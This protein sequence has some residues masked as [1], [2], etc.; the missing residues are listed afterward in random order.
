MRQSSF[1]EK[2]GVPQILPY[3][4]DHSGPCLVDQ[5]ARHCQIGLVGRRK[6][7]VADK[8]HEL[9]FTHAF[10]KAVGQCRASQIVK[11]TTLTDARSW[12]RPQQ[13]EILPREPSELT[14]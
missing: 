14:C 12:Q 2:Q 9:I 8:P 7:C 1:S 11:S 4:G 6:T 5:V 13:S 3:S 10:G